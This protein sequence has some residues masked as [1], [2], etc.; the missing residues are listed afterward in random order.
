MVEAALRHADSLRSDDVMIVGAWCRG[1]QHHALGHRF[2]TSA[3]R[4]L[5]LALALSSWDAYRALAEAF[6]SVGD[7]GIRFRIA[8]VTVDLLP[9]GDI[10]GPQGTAQP[11]TRGENMSVWAFEEIFAASLPLLPPAVGTVRIPTVA[12]YAAAKLGA[13]LDRSE[14]FEAKDAAD[15]ALVLYWYGESGAVHER[16]YDTSAGNEILIAESADVP[17]AAAHMLG[18]DVAT[19]IGP[20]RLAELLAR[21]PGNLNLL[22]HELNVA[23]GAAW[24]RDGRRRRDLVDALTRGMTELPSGG[25]SNLRGGDR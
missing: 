17:L 12:G 18:V 22:I 1:I 3:T 16:L 8:D 15:L 23:S 9:F 24:T 2:A 14:W 25:A 13:W 4:D 7:T 6:P 10:E 5:D 20:D 21:W 19:T 11:P